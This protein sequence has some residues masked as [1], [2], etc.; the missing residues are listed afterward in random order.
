MLY[1]WRE[2]IF[3]SMYLCFLQKCSSCFVN[4]YPNADK[5]GN[6]GNAGLLSCAT[7]AMISVQF[8]SNIKR[9]RLKNGQHIVTS[10]A[11][12]RR[13]NVS[14]YFDTL[15][16]TLVIQIHKLSILWSQII[17]NKKGLPILYLLCKNIV[18]NCPKE[19][20]WEYRFFEDIFRKDDWVTLGGV[21]KTGLF[22]HIF[23]IFL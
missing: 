5:I 6:S 20:V 23:I 3:T 19:R 10:G 11:E 12:G 9:N 13:E 8:L 1:F 15:Y 14:V 7:I 2:F 21:K 17:K 18:P 16:N 22:I 4:Y